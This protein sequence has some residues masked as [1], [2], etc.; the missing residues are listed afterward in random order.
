MHIDSV[1]AK[2]RGTDLFSLKFFAAGFNGTVQKL[3]HSK[4]RAQKHEKKVTVRKTNYSTIQK[5]ENVEV[6]VSPNQSNK[7]TQ[8][9][10][11]SSTTPLF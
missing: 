7:K 9:I 10:Q 11:H 1:E 6:T 2:T 5:T 3:E 4:N 8:N